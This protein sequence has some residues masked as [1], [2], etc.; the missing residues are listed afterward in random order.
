[1]RDACL[2]EALAIIEREGVESLSL[3]E[4]SRRLGVS[5]QAPYR[6]F[7]SRDHLLAEIVA[8]A[9]RAFV[10]HLEAR[11]RTG[12]AQGDLR[13]MGR[14]YLTYARAHP[15]QY[16]L[17]FGTPLPNPAEHPDM[18]RHAERAFGLL[19]D[20]IAELPSTEGARDLRATHLDALFVWST[21]HGLS[22]IMSSDAL[23]TVD[24]DDDLLE[25]AAAETLRRI[26]FGLRASKSD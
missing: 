20:A 19:R 7:P 17:M 3:R 1:M 10:A 23:D 13:E 4:V 22:S 8:G 16:R 5:H 12:G 18:M 6:H 24:L 9:Y 21:L 15:L 25:A 14:A 11:P 2:A 26:G